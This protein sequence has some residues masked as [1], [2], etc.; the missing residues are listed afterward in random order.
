MNSRKIIAAL[1]SQDINNFDN[2]SCA[3]LKTQVAQA[4][5]EDGPGPFSFCIFETRSFARKRDLAPDRRDLSEPT[6]RE[7]SAAELLREKRAYHRQI[8]DC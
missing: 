4:R 1:R 2:L 8:R 6:C 5:P 7:D 3:P